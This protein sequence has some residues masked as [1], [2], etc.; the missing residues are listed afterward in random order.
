MTLHLSPASLIA[1]NK[2]KQK[3][4]REAHPE[5][6]RAFH[7][8]HNAREETKQR[9]IQWARD[10]REHINARRREQYRQRKQASTD[11]PEATTE[12]SGDTTS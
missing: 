3:E 10:N 8:K 2:R 7:I 1:R 9:K 12:D 4:W 11:P 5:R 6:A